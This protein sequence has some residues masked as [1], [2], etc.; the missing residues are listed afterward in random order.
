MY[1]IFYSDSRQELG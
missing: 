1:H